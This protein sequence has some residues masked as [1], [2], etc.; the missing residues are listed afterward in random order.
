M[1]TSKPKVFVTRNDYPE[2]SIKMLKEKCDV[3]I[4]DG[5]KIKK[6][7]II[8]GVKGKDALYCS[9]NDK[10]DKDVLNAGDRLK[11][12]G[13]M[14]VG[15]DHI[16][17]KSCKQLGIKVGYTPGVLTE[18]VAE[19]GVA[20]LLATSRRLIEGY[21]EVACG[22]WSSWSPLWMCG[23]GLSGST[24]G[25]VG[26]GNVGYEVGR[27]L[28]AFRVKCFL[29]SNPTDSPVAKELEAKRVCLEELLKE[30]DFVIVSC[31]LNEETKELFDKEKFAL[32][33]NTAIFINIS[34]GGVVKQDDLVDALENKVIGAAGLD[35]TVPEPL[36]TDHPLLSF[37]NCVVV[38]HI[39]S[40]TVKTRTEMG[41]LTTQN[42]LAGVEGKPLPKEYGYYKNI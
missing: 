32:M 11:V 2:I 16:D 10:I 18:A 12:V 7:E 21:N 33:K 5:T 35:V 1:S 6:E 4:Y 15:I 14:S 38:P 27:K 31:T 24:V 41:N 19:L 23:Q 30:S 40:A 8:D 34:R 25:I 28:K 42:I 36:P 20:L 17:I 29:Y 13:T 26:L 3:E 9:L 39:G 37:P 22:G